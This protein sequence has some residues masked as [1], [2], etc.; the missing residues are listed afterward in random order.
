MLVGAILGLGF[1][2]VGDVL[3][4]PFEKE[5][6]IQRNLTDVDGIIVLGGG[7]DVAASHRA[8]QP[9][10][11]EA[12]DRY[13]AALALARDF[14]DARLIFAGGSGRLRD[15]VGAKVSEAEVA[16]QFF[17]EQGVAP[18]RLLFEDQSSN[19]AENARLSRVLADPQG[20]EK[21]VLVT[22]AFHLPRAMNS[23]S[24]AGWE[25]IVPYP[26]DFRTRDLSD[27]M[28]WNFQRNLGL[29]NI[30]L[31]EWVGRAAYSVTGR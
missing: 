7:E 23:F 16:R 26:V 11:N 3:I 14:P 17:E 4:R 12:A 1:F 22:S 5:F 9:Q 8:G 18:E 20:R 24:R 6:S 28:G 31:R 13:I 27:G 2:P 21:W 25:N 15:M 30:A 29:T 19:T 10:F